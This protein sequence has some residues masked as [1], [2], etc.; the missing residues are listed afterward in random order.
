MSK[1]L[2]THENASDLITMT[3]DFYRTI[4][5]WQ[6]WH[7][8]TPKRVQSLWEV[9]LSTPY[10]L[11]P[12]SFPPVRSLV[13]YHD[14]AR[15]VIKNGKWKNQKNEAIGIRKKNWN[16]IWSRYCLQLFHLKTVWAITAIARVQ[17]HWCTG[18]IE[19]LLFAPGCFWTLDDRR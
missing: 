13:L 18:G 12:L 14:F 10:Y 15:A 6:R 2:V 3:T 17:V 5:L 7:K 11:L 8:M 1:S 4:T 9:L 19:I 16:R